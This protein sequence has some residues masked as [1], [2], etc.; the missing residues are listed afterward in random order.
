MG[1]DERRPP[2]RLSPKTCSEFDDLSRYEK[3]VLQ[4]DDIHICYFVAAGIFSWLLLAG[5]LVSPS[6]YASIQHSDVMDDAGSVAQSV[7]KVV[8]NV[9]LLYIASFM[10]GTAAVGLGWLTYRWLNNPVWIK[11]NVVV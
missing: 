4:I 6:T 11:R 9:P 10:F 8:R 2:G 5:Y 7:F 3:M 1:F